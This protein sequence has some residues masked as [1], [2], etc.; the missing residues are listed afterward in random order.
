MMINNTTGKGSASSSWIRVKM[1]LK[2]P[3]VHQ[4]K[5]LL[6]SPVSDRT[7][8]Q[9]GAAFRNCSYSW[10][11]IPWRNLAKKTLFRILIDSIERKSY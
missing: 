9:L 1:R 6:A 5:G 10:D 7:A 8:P 2:P 3:Q 11:A 4:Y